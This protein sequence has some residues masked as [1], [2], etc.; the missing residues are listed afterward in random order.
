MVAVTGGAFSLIG[1]A[2][3]ASDPAD[4]GTALG[5]LDA[6]TA[7]E[8]LAGTTSVP[9]GALLVSSIGLVAPV[10]A[11][12]DA[13]ELVRAVQIAEETA[14]LAA[15]RDAADQR[16]AKAKADAQRKAAER[17]SVAAVS[18]GCGLNTSGLGA[19]Q[20]HVRKAAE[21]LGCRYGRPTMHGVAGR[22][23]PSDHPAGRA[24]DFM[25]DRATGDG[26]AA[27]AL[28]NKAALGITYVIWQQRINYGNGWVPM[29][30]RG[31]ATANHLDHV[32][33]SFAPGAG[34]GD[35][36]GC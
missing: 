35:L 29:E 19:V 8:T 34:G 24:V 10:P 13:G 21:F 23:G 12:V 26:L 7:V 16:T 36:T 32:H 18:A 3:P 9:P 5:P 33:I 28:R 20:P 15:E 6:G 27:C 30:D 1:A 31:G 4:A 22:G 11:P 17:K 2:A 25:V 14:R